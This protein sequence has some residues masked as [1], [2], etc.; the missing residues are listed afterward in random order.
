MGYIDSKGVTHEDNTIPAS[1]TPGDPQDDTSDMTGDIS[2]MAA[3]IGE[4]PDTPTLNT[5]QNTPAGNHTDSTPKH[6]QHHPQW[7]W[8]TSGS[9]LAIGLLAACAGLGYGLWDA[10]QQIN[11]QA[12]QACA[13]SVNAVHNAT[14]QWTEEYRKLQN[15]MTGKT[16]SMLQNPT[17]LAQADSLL[18]QST[19]PAA[20]RC[21]TT[22]ASSQTALKQNLN[23]IATAYQVTARLQTMSRQ[24]SDELAMK[25]GTTLAATRDDLINQTNQAASLAAQATGKVEQTQPLA[26]LNTDITAARKQAADPASSLQDLQAMSRKLTVDTQTVA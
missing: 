7:P 23:T 11:E 26:A 2:D 5:P 10:N 13:L 15:L 17:V 18:E 6:G 16:A 9:I 12:G 3:R 1:I 4:N 21:G 25:Q 20:T 22:A 14:K 24:V 19:P 8:I